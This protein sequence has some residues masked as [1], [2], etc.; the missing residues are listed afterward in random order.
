M[1]DTTKIKLSKSMFPYQSDKADIRRKSGTYYTG[2][3]CVED[4]RRDGRDAEEHLRE[5]GGG[6]RIFPTLI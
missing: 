1:N 5:G 4:G 6:K 3:M 2:E